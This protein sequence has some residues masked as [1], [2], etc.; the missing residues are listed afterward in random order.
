LAKANF[1]ADKH[2]LGVW[3]FTPAAADA[4]PVAD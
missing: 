3:I 1:V 2:L 4:F